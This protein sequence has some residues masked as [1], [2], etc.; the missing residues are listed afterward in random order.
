MTE[1]GLF[2][3]GIEEEFQIVDPETGEMSKPTSLSNIYEPDINRPGEGHGD[4]RGTEHAF[5]SLRDAQKGTL[6]IIVFL[7]MKKQQ[8]ALDKKVKEIHD[9]IKAVAEKHG[10]AMVN[11]RLE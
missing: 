9:E 7:M 11:L 5:L 4:I 2:T 8:E 3:L 1:P 6:K 10:I